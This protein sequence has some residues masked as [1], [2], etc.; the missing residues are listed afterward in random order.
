MLDEDFSQQVEDHINQFGDKESKVFLTK[1]EHD[2]C[3]HDSDEN[4]LEDEYQRG[5]KNAMVDFQRQM[6][7][8]NRAVHISKLPRKN[9]IDQASPGKLHDT[10]ADKEKDN[11]EESQN[12]V[13]R[14]EDPKEKVSKE[15]IQ[16]EVPDKDV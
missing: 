2:R 9:I 14:E 12:E 15:L 4:N 6:N 7:W 16:K 13:V 5:Y 8:R 11:K 10:T 1:E 3:T